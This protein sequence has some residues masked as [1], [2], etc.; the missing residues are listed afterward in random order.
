VSPRITNNLVLA[1]ARHRPA[2][3]LAMA[4]GDLIRQL[5]LAALFAPAAAAR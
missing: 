3:R 1:S 5:N 4:T 2:T